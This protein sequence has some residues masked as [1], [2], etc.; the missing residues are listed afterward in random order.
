MSSMKIGERLIGGDAPTFIVA[1]LSANHRQD[2]ASARRLVEAAA[3][4]GADAVKLQT[5]R[6]ETMTLDSEQ[7]C[8]RIQGGTLWDGRKLYDLYQE[9][10]TP[11]EWHA[12]LAELA[13]ALGLIWFSSP[14]DATAVDFLEGLACPAYKIASFE[15]VDLPLLRH[16]A[17]TKKPVIASTGM[18]MRE[19]IG[20]AVR[21]LRAHGASQIALLQ[22][23]SGYPAEPDEM[24]LRN[25]PELGRSFEVVPGLSDHTLGIA[26]PVAAVA[27]GAR[28]VEKHLTLARADGGPDA[29]F[30]LEPEEF[31]EMVRA[32]RVAE[33]ATRTLAFGPTPR[34]EASL[35]F[36]RSLFVAE[37]MQEGER[38]TERNV[39][40]VRP[41]HGLHPRH[42]AEV[43]GRRA[44]RAIEKGTPLSWDLVG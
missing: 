15:L 39:R 38:F 23:N 36:R 20:E 28:V 1:E 12:E 41:A 44:T 14:F 18:A 2:L 35:V 34:E 21:T 3:R 16:V 13:G 5:Y 4:A 40:C 19:E 42:L 43:L 6:A 7:P 26:V 32:V 9:A 31:A 17:R 10:H 33:A 24:R 27:L 29:A 37:D 11:W 25:I 8:F 22:A 30:S